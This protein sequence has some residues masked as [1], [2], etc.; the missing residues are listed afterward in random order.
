MSAIYRD[1]DQ[2][3]L[4]DQYNALKSS[5]NVDDVRAR[6]ELGNEAMRGAP[7]ARL[8]FAYGQSPRERIDVFAAEVEGAPLLVFI[9]GGYWRARTKEEFTFVG[10]AYRDAGISVALLE[11]DL[12]P[13]VT[14]D[15]I[16]RQCRSALVWL[17]RHGAELGLDAGRMF[18]SGHSAGGHL[19]AMMV[20]TEW[21]DFGADVPRDLVKGAVAISGLYD[22]EPISLTYLQA[23]VRLDQGLIARNSPVNL[24]PGAPCPLILA[25]GGGEPAEFHRQSEILR[26]AWADAGMTIQ[27]LPVGALNH[28]TILDNFGTLGE[29]LHEKTRAMMI[30]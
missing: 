2:Q 22:L 29:E 8:D 25:L 6:W 17:W 10:R 1:Y 26:A 30:G 19:T 14:M 4:D 9:H 23:D 11:Y 7:W 20:A 3:G 24:R 13:G 28:F 12:A 27:V 5:G 16:V 18:V 21:S 15:V